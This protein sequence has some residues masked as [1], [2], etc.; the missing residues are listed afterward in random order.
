M[1]PLN[2][3][4]EN[5]FLQNPKVQEA[6]LRSL[7]HARGWIE[8]VVY[9]DRMS[10]ADAARPAYQRLMKDARRGLFQAV[11]VWRFDRFARSTKELINALEEFESLG[12]AFVSHQEAI[13]TSTP[14][15]KVMFTIIAAFAEFERDIIR[16][17]I[18]AGLQHARSHGT[19]SGKPIGGQRKIFKRGE[20]IRL[21][22]EGHSYRE[23]SRRLKIALGTVHRACSTDVRGES[24]DSGRIQGL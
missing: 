15:G 24:G 8:D 12:I 1:L 17:R 14:M 21:R 4:E 13:D 11:V 10:G 16:E 7:I 5:Q 9:V 19:K 18:I 6:P 20:A 23:I 2:Q 3:R 22:E